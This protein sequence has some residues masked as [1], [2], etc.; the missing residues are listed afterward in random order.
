MTSEK[1]IK[2]H[3]LVLAGG[4]GTRSENPLMPKILQ[5]ISDEQKLIDLHFTNLTRQLNLKITFLLGHLHDPVIQ[6][7]KEIETE[8]DYEI[9]WVLDKEGE[10]PVTAILASIQKEINSE[11]IFVIRGIRNAGAGSCSPQ[12]SPK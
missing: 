8:S 4:R 3:A 2:A 7:I 11:A 5:S 10:T 1:E 6:K 12:P 9:D